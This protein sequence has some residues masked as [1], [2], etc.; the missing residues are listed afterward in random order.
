MSNT[1]DLGRERQQAFPPYVVSD[2]QKRRWELA[3][4]A[5]LIVYGFDPDNPDEVLDRGDRMLLLQVVP[6]LYVNEEYETG[7][8]EITE[9]Q[10]RAM[11]AM[12][13][14]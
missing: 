9:Q 5:T 14:L 8:G 12:G 13:A 4:R 1:E 3:T 6:S 10:R 11:R 2:E 7:E